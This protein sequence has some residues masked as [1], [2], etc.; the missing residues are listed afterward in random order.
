M[1]TRRK[2]MTMSQLK[3]EARD[4]FFWKEFDSGQLDER[5]NNETYLWKTDL[6]NCI[7]D[8][9]QDEEF[10]SW[11]VYWNKIV[12]YLNAIVADALYNYVLDNV[13]KWHCTF[14]NESR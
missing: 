14:N 8:I 4:R 13:E 12:D 10:N 5:I 1:A 3:R 9:D 2:Y 11:W 7:R 6:L